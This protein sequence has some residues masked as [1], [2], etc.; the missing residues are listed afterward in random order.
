MK[1]NYVINRTADMQDPLGLYS[2]RS[3]ARKGFSGPRWI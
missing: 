3:S 1:I 2:G